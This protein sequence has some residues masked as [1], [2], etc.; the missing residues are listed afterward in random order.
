MQ[1]FKHLTANNVKLKPFLFPRELSMEAYLID[2]EKVLI[3]DSDNFSEIEIIE[4]ELTLKQGR[5]S[6]DADGRI[7]ILAIYNEI[8]IA[9]I[10]L[11]KGEITYTHIKQLEDYMKQRSQILTAF[12]EEF[13]D[14]LKKDPK[15][16]GIVVG[17]SIDNDLKN[18]INS[19]YLIEK[20]IPVAVLTINRYRGDD[21]QIYVLTET[22]FNNVSRNYD[23]TKYKFNNDIFGKSRLVL[24]VLKKHCKDNPELT[25]HDLEKQFPQEIQGSFYGVFTSQDEAKRIIEN[26]KHQRHFIKPEEIITL[27]DDSRIVICTQWGIGNINRFIK[28]ARELKYG[29]EE[30]KET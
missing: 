10:E 28:R 27:K 13:S 11:K 29:I 26:T 16:I 9:I 30:I 18:K 3:L 22:C 4:T 2:N 14:D 6:K 8:T 1:L 5:K 17:T 23:R 24:A 20:S 21:N 12:A 15:W 7:D 25:F 19:G